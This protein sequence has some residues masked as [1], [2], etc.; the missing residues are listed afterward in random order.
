MKK[1]LAFAVG[2]AVAH[3]PASLAQDYVGAPALFKRLAELANELPANPLAGTPGGVLSGDLRKFRSDAAA[4]APEEAAARWLALVDRFAA[5]DGRDI[6][7]VSSAEYASDGKQF[8]FKALLAALPPPGAWDALAKAIEARPKPA[9]AKAV[10]ES[11]L[12]IV[13]HTL[14]NAPDARWQDAAN[15][16]AIL[17]KAHNENASYALR[18]LSAAL[19]QSDPDPKRIIAGFEEQLAAMEASADE[20]SGE[21]LTLPDLVTLVG[22][23]AAKKLIKRALLLP[24]GHG[25]QIE[26]GEATKKLARQIALE[27]AAQIK[28]PPWAIMDSPDSLALFEAMQKRFPAR[29]RDD[30]SER[31]TA[32]GYY[33]LGLIAANRTAEAV[34]FAVA[35]GTREGGRRFSMSGVVRALS[36]AGEQRA[37][38]DFLAVLLAE[39]PGM[40]EL[41]FAFI[42]LGPQTGG[43]D[44][45]LAALRAALARENLP[46]RTH[47]NLRQQLAT[48]LLAADQI[49]D[50]VKET[51][52]VIAMPLPPRDDSEDFTPR[53][54]RSGFAARLAR[55][56]KL[57]KRQEW[58][59]AGLAT[60]R[61][62]GEENRARGEFSPDVAALFVEMGRGPEA[63]Q[64]LIEDVL[65]ASR[66]GRGRD[67]GQSRS[68]ANPL[69]ELLQ[70]Y[71]TA[72]RADD[73]LALL[74]GAPGWGVADITGIKVGYTDTSLLLPAA[75]ALAAKGRTDEARRLV[76]AELDA[77]GGLDP[78]YALLLQLGGDGVIA[79]LD[80]LAAR[81]RF[82]E[83]P[84]I[85]KAK[86]Q[87]DAGQIEDA[88]K[89]VRA[90]IA[91]DPSDGEQPK[92]DRM[93]AYA[94]LAGILEKKG[95]GA[96]AKI[97]RGAVEAI[98][99]SEAADDWANAGLLTRAAQMYG[100]ALTHFADAYCIQSRLAL[101]F[102]ELGQMDK[103]EEH[104]RRAFELMP[105]SFGRVESHCFGCEHAFSGERA[106][107]IAE[108]VF[109]ALAAQPGAKPQIH[110]LLGYLRGQ[111]GRAPEA[112]ASYRRAVTLD[113]DYLNAWKNIAALGD[114]MRLPAADAD[115]AV[116][117]QI[118]LDPLNRHGGRGT[119]RVADLKALWQAV[120]AA[121]K[122]RPAPHGDLYPLAA[123]KAALGH[124]EAVPG[125]GARRSQMM[126]RSRPEFLTPGEVVAETAV[127][128]AAGQVFEITARY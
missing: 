128:E 118:R 93:R 113:P 44:K 7:A 26:H 79:R 123:S 78:A 59:D 57:M 117:N 56:G 97:M 75:T 127:L 16:R 115:A 32:S 63:E 126:T 74:D 51:L 84:L 39:H 33:L 120:E 29:E 11:A 15:L 36:H 1:H 18:S 98:R 70:L 45:M 3:L 62:L 38:F 99:L 22:E 121:G 83:R 6:N 8:N 10:S 42:E 65:A 95:D 76:N 80:E 102:A 119:Q 112:L 81:D 114:E 12:R 47:I 91:I 37:V 89:T 92:G 9:G 41:W 31:E 69:A 110:Y 52:A 107:G 105:D 109:T 21:S 5:L 40:N 88:E 66:P 25:F 48:A 96:Q 13:A 125:D 122:L 49:E 116:L 58:I 28:T 71:H 43:T 101:R 24:R 82:E 53:D 54:L 17:K 4:L 103:A 14:V 20:Q 60:A 86:L 46:A 30:F 35:P 23:P 85:W 2:L 94:V 68:L 67:Y 106:Q 19:L 64:W 111:Q 55:I 34:K 73:V 61:K 72:G 100:D 77:K 87:L 124:A 50:G 104:Y 90:A 27:S 108:K